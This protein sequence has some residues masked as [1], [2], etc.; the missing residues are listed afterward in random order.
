M[1]SQTFQAEQ[2]ERLGTDLELALGTSPKPRT[3]LSAAARALPHKVTMGTAFGREGCA[4]I[5]IIATEGLNVDLFTIDTGL[6]FDE[7]YAL[8]ESLERRYGILIR[9]VRPKETIQ[10]QGARLG[11][12]LWKHQP[13]R[14]CFLRKVVPLREQ[15]AMFD[16]WVTGVRRAQGPSRADA[17]IVTYEQQYNV[18]KFNPLA[19][20]SDEELDTFIEKHAIPT[21]PLHERGFPSIGC[22][23]CTSEVKPGE[24]ARAGRWRGRSKTECGIHVPTEAEASQ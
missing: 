21:N 22:W 12:A 10:Q 11:P 23:P 3:V 18:I 17:P 13:N 15:L 6:F 24:D 4:I 5:H 9:A 14:C 19:A 7:T 1:A 8:W 16:G 2:L 20:W